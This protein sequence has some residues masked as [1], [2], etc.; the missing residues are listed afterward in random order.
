MNLG[1]LIRVRSPY[2]IYLRGTIASRKLSKALALSQ[3]DTTFEHDSISMLY[4]SKAILHS[5][6][7]TYVPKINALKWEAQAVLNGD[8]LH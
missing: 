3:W 8:G 7:F 6:S 1:I 4:I 5:N 2:S